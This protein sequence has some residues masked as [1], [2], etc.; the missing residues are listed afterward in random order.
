[1]AQVVA[2]VLVCERPQNCIFGTYAALAASLAN[3]GLYGLISHEA[4]LSMRDIGVRLGMGA[5]RIAV[6]MA[7]YRR[8]SLILSG[9][10]LAGLLLAEA[11]RKLIAANVSI[12]TAKDLAVFV[13]LAGALFITGMLALV[14][15]RRAASV[16]PMVMLRSE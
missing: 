7:K 4:E 16:D 13:G 8:V 10:V 2:D 14:P 3:A 9:G 11:K 1:V 6:L 15:A 5:T 12:R